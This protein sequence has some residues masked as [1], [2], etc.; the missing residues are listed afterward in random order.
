MV[1]TG[2]VVDYNDFK[3]QK[4]TGNEGKSSPPA[5]YREGRP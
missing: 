4:D 5:A 2:W 1:D 3:I